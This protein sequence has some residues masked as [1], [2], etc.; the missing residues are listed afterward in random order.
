MLLSIE[1]ADARLVAEVVKGLRKARAILDSGGEVTEF[2]AAA[3]EEIKA[4]DFGHL[5]V[6]FVT[7]E[8]GAL[9]LEVL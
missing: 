3:V 9:A 2:D 1:R 7:D 5:Q 4:M 8:S 6:A